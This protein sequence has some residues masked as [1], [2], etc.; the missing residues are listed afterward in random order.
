MLRAMSALLFVCLLTGG[1]YAAPLNPGTLKSLA[2][3]ANAHSVTFGKSTAIPIGYF[4]LCKAGHPVCNSVR[5]NLAAARNGAVQITRRLASDLVTI[6]HQVNNSIRPRRGDRWQVE[7]RFGDCKDYALTKK[8]RLM[9]KGWPSSALLVAT[10]FTA[11]GVRHAVLIVRTDR[12]DVVLDNL[13]K[14]VRGWTP[15]LYR[16]LA[17]QSPSKRY[18][19]LKLGSGVRAR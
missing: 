1:S 12:G 8:S 13:T 9:S 19:W 10:A 7:P 16:W 15:T 14:K 6:N 17:I 5:G 18:S 3:L 11:A 2:L 4:Q